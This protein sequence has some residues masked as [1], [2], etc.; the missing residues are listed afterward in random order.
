[1]RYFV[2]GGTGFIGGEVVRQLA[3]AGHQVT[4]LAR[5]ATKAKK[6]ARTGV[7]VEMGDVTVKESMREAMK[8]AYGVF[9]LA[10]WYR[11]G[12]RRGRQAARVNMVGTRN[13]L[14][15]IKEL[16]IPKGVHTSTIMVFSDTKGKVVDESYRASG[17]WLAEYERSKWKGHYEI[18]LP[19]M[20]EGLP[21]V[22][23]QPGAVYGPGDTGPLSSVLTQY[24]QKK[25]PLLPSRAAYCWV[26]VEDVARGHILA[27]ERGKPGESYVLAN[28]CHTLIETLSI[29]E[30]ITG[31]PAPRIHVSPGAMR[32][33]SSIAG[34]L[35]SLVPLPETY[36]SE[37][38]RVSAGATFLASSEKARRELGF[39]T[40]PFEEGLRETLQWQMERLGVRSRDGG[41]SRAGPCSQAPD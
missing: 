7:A 4:V 16:E 15:L 21:V 3:Q 10:G 18:A 17:P 23:V 40:R 39:R 38:L 14:E 6:L 37:A 2:T 34:V 11:I 36:S 30:K 5:S 27:M 28:S 35:E 8:G 19:M 32:L 9:H 29:A 24:L 31:I 33:M 25:L 22:V 20:A 41:G 26:H 12:A 1:M 13:V